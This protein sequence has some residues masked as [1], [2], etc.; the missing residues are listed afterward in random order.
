M[1]IDQTCLQL[2][3]SK[4]SV[5]WHKQASEFLDE[6]NIPP[7]PLCLL[8]AY[9]YFSHRRP[10]L[11]HQVTQRIR[12]DSDVDA[13]FLRDLFEEHCINQQ[14][15]K[16][17][18]HIADLQN[19][20]FKVLEGVSS[21][22]LETETYGKVLEQQSAALGKNP[23][24]E[25]LKKIAGNLMHATNKAIADNGKMREHLKA[26]EENS[27]KLQN[28]V[29]TLKEETQKDPLTGLYNRKAL[30]EQL[31]EV[32]EKVSRSNR[33]MTLCM[34]D[35]DHFKSF[36]D[37]YGH[38]IGDQVIRLVSKTL[39]DQSR[40]TDFPARYGGEEF[41]LILA[42]TSMDIASKVAGRI[43]EAIA[44]LVLVKRNSQERLPSIT[45]SMG[46]ACLQTGDNAESLL[47]RADKALYHAK[48]TGR[49]KIVTEYE[50][51]VA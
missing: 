30:N 35:I 41:T 5:E 31:D 46:L 36:N 33:D 20:L 2:D 50:L 11:N 27:I 10:K 7:N 32:I 8:V 1:S 26:A 21:A 14:E 44:K 39:L 13:F 29:Q 17:E 23:S 48:E 4:R 24:L 47:S 22:G 40:D 16:S 28:Q 25:D 43:H 49:N 3:I 6:H 45:V 38:Q 12:S 34:F 18:K 51:N 19:M 37:N 9:K 42:D 15:G